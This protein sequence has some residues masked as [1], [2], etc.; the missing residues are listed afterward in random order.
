LRLRAPRSAIAL[1]VALVALTV[2]LVALTLRREP[3][4]E[5]AVTPAEPLEA[6]DTLVGPRRITLDTS[7]PERWVRFHFS[8]GGAVPPG[9]DW[10]I[11]FRRFNVLVNGGGPFPGS[12]AVVA[13]EGVPFDRVRTAPVDGWV[14]AGAGRDSANPAIARWYDYGF[15]SHRLTPRPV[16]YVIRT[17]DGRFAKLRFL[18]YYCTGAAP[19]CITF[20]YVY[21][22]DGTRMLDVERGAAPGK[23]PG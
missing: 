20:E 2:A 4:E 9:G 6:G 18:S 23:P 3:V 11:A 15:V 22:G 14:Q 1:S 19:G 8:T 17:A 13:L 7:D 12:A 5:Y 16:V 10:D 21:Q